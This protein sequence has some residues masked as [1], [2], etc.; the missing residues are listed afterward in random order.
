MSFYDMGRLAQTL[1]LKQL[2]GMDGGKTAEL[3][4]DAKLINKPPDGGRPCSD[5]ICVLDT[6]SA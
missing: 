6:P 5:Y 2:Y 1:G 4:F 3:A